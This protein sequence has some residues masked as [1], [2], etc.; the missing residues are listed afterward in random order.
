M[1]V[2]LHP[3]SG[4]TPLADY[5]I[6]LTLRSEGIVMTVL[7]VFSW[8]MVFDW[9]ETARFLEADDRVRLQRRLILDKQGPTAEGYDKRYIYEAIKDWKTYGY[10]FIYMG[11]LMPL[12]AF[13]LFLPT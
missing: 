5:A 2:D 7:G 9:P 1:V 12:Y 6:Q 13:S 8:W 11:C 4:G 3:V 10:M